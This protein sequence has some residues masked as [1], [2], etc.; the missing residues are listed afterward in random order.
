VLRPLAVPQLLAR[1]DS[2]PAADLHLGRRVVR[3]RLADLVLPDTA[4]PHL[5]LI[6]LSVH[7][8]LYWLR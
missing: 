6:R 3:I 8:L 4:F 2:A 7:G 1:A 5:T